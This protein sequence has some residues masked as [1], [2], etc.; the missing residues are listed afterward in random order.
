M[1]ITKLNGFRYTEMV[2][3]IYS[4]EDE[5]FSIFQELTMAV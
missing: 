2:F 1:K 5:E 4:F 3:E